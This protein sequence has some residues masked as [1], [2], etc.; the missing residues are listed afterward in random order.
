MY[1]ITPDLDRKN[2]YLDSFWQIPLEFFRYEI[3]TLESRALADRLTICD[4]SGQQKTYQQLS[5]E[6]KE[7][8]RMANKLLRD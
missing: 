8:I 4:D 2:L 3:N 7:L 5:P 1:Q 6:R